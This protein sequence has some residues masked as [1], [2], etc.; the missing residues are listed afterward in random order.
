M[1]LLLPQIQVYPAA[2][3]A[4]ARTRRTTRGLRADRNRRQAAHLQQCLHDVPLDALD[5]LPSSCSCSRG[6]VGALVFPPHPRVEDDLNE[7]DGGEKK[8]DGRV[9]SLSQTP[10]HMWRKIEKRST[11]TTRGT[12]GHARRWVWCSGFRVLSVETQ[13]E[14]P[15][16]HALPL[17]RAW[18]GAFQ[19]LNW[20]I[21]FRC[22]AVLA[23]TLGGLFAAPARAGVAFSQFRFSLSALLFIDAMIP[24]I[25]SRPAFAFRSWKKTHP[26]DLRK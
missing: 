7:A 15:A 22:W 21:T 4:W 10:W 11:Q 24:R 13:T 8:R 18:G 2:R 12:Q 26:Q 20:C 16:P 3:H 17:R 23:M 19:P 25:F 6:G 1:L 5:G 9:R 14:G